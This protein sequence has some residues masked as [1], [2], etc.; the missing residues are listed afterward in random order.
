MKTHKSSHTMHQQKP[1]N[2]K[3]AEARCNDDREM[4]IIDRDAI[5]HMLHPKRFYKPDASHF[6]HT[7]RELL[8]G[9]E[10]IGAVCDYEW[11]RAVEEYERVHDQVMRWIADLLVTRLMDDGREWRCQPW[12]TIPSENPAAAKLTK[13]AKR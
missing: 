12:M 9:L 5:F 4:E 13:G 6:V 8:D 7:V 2:P 3:K 11:P 10:G 1:S